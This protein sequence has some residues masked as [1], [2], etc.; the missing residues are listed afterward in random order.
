MRVS[1]RLWVAVAGLGVGALGTSAQAVPP[2]KEPQE[3]RQ[4]PPVPRLG[5]AR[6]TAPAL[7]GADGPAGAQ[8]NVNGSGLN[9]VGDAGNEP[10]IAIDPG[11]PN[12]IVIGWRQ[13]DTIASNFREAGVNYS[14][15]GG[16]TWAAASELDSG[17]FRSDPVLDSDLQGNFY[18]HSLR[19][20]NGSQYSCQVYR[21]SDGG[22]T[23]QGPFDAFGGDKAWFAVDKTGL[24][25]SGQMYA[26][27]DYA[28]CCGNNWFSRSVNGGLAWTSPVPIPTEPIWG[29]LTIASNGDVLIG[30]RIN[31]TQ[32]YTFVRSTSAKNPLA[33]PVFEFTSPVNLGGAQNIAVPNTPNPGGL[34]GMVWLAVDRTSVPSPTA[35]NLYML[36]SVDPPGADPC[37]LMFT[38]S[39]N[40][41]VAWSAPVRLSGDPVS[42]NSYQWFGTISVAPNGR[43]DVVWNDT[44]KD[45]S[46]VPNL[47]ELMYRSSFDGGV[48]WTSELVLTPQ[49]DSYLGWPNQQKLGDYY[50]MISDKVGAT[51]AYAATFNGEQDVYCL[52]IGD[53]DCNGNGVPDSIDL[54]QGVAKD[55]NANGI[56][57]SCEIAAGAVKDANGNGVPDDCE[58]CYADCDASGNLAIDDFI[59]FQTLFA[60]GDPSAD[61]DE[62]G[63][64]SIDDFICFQTLFAIGC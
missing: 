2:D 56:P 25:S 43:I 62:S 5:P 14:L 36:C 38:R 60:I 53:Y 17:V 44:R 58:T 33:T 57:D 59:C 50:H 48:S 6:A 54:T 22:A 7:G 47:S 12:R 16:R 18:Y 13:F 45:T 3:K 46:G 31:N 8:V 49:F 37:E 21:S 19:V 11:A 55:C 63:D 24:A 64:L 34:L 28:G 41:G 15:D 1:V 26:G 4:D 20:I 42:S 27:W 32:N 52:R 9:I 35:G 61:C 10:S 40:G 23:W 39:T 51:L 29:A 30:G